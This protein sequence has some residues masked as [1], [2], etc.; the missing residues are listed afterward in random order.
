MGA[1]M[2]NNSSDT[3]D[4]L[5]RARAGDRD[6]L[7]D[8]FARHRDRLCRMVEMR[9]RRMQGQYLR[10]LFDRNRRHDPRWPHPLLQFVHSRHIPARASLIISTSLGWTTN[11]S[12]NDRVGYEWT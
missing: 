7:D 1:L 4:L 2:D 3:A 6:A 10:H 9:E 8:I 12:P 5:H 11:T